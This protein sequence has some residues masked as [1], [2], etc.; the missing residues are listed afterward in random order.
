MANLVDTLAEA[1][2]F[3]TLLRAIRATGLDVTLSGNRPFTLFAPTDDAF[4]E[5]PRSAL[6]VLF[7]DRPTLLEVMMYHLLKGW[8]PANEVILK[9]SLVALNG[10]RLAVDAMDRVKV[11]GASVLQ[12]DREADNGIIHTVDAV[13]LPN[14]WRGIKSPVSSPLRGIGKASLLL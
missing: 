9:P 8:M 2:T 1:G 12:I 10:Q 3:N 5:L 6:E 14:S 11:N 7:K 4:E 13:L